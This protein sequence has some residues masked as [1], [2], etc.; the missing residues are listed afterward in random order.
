MNEE[1]YI[2]DASDHAGRCAIL[3]DAPTMSRL[4]DEVRLLAYIESSDCALAKVWRW[5]NEARSAI[6]LAGDLD[7]LSLLDYAGRILF[8]R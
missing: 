2:T 6:C 5:P 1:G 3:L 4:G 8:W 7:A